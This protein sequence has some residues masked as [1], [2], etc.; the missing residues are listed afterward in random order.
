MGPDSAYAGKNLFKIQP[1]NPPAGIQWEPL[2]ARED[3]AT[4]FFQTHLLEGGDAEKGAG[5]YELKLELFNPNVSKD[6]P[7]D[8]TAAQ[9]EVKVPTVIASFG[10]AIVSTELADAEHLIRDDLGN[11][12][13]FRVVVRVDNN[14][15][16][17][18]ICPVHNPSGSSGLTLDANCGFNEYSNKSV[19]VRLAFK[20]SHPHNF[21]AFSFE[22][23]RGS[24]IF[25]REASAGVASVAA[26]PV[27]GFVL[28]S[29]GVYVKDNVSVDTLLTSNKTPGSPDCQS[30]AFVE[31]LSV[32]AMATD[33]WSTPTY[34]GATADPKAFALT[35]R[36]PK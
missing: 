8:L 1:L 11:L 13:G 19:N 23:N 17:G 4:A 14:L 3:S 26:S 5:K 7:V 35:P 10:S 15:C 2:D 18:E 25:V 30:A 9:V 6:K 33:G 36:P 27:N 31:S 32:S 16:K 34:L 24:A 29:S 12:V 21:A 20:A 22:I 28:N